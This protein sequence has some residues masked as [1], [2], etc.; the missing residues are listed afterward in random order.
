MD[1][2]VEDNGA[3]ARYEARAGDELAGSAEYRLSDGT[4]TFTHTVVDDAFE[5]QGVGSALARRALD[6]AR[7]RGLGVVPQCSFIRDWIDKHPD[8]QDLVVS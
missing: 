2:S 7:E 1:I 4:V 6:D 3:A 8:Y 5:G